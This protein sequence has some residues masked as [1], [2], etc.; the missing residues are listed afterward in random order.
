MWRPCGV[1]DE[2][3]QK[4]M[5]IV[6]TPLRW[7]ALLASLL[8]LGI[9]PQV[10]SYHLIS[11]VNNVAITV[12]LV[13]GLQVVS[14]YCGQ[15]S[16]GQA[17]FMAVGAY[18][19]AI[20]TEKM[21]I[22]FW[23]AMPVAGIF[24][25]IFGLVG[26]APSLRI[27]GFY[28]AIA[29]IAVH[30]VTMWL[31]LHLEITEGSR[32]LTVK[33]PQLWSVSLDTDE[34]MYYVIIPVMLLMTYGAKN[35]T[36]TRVGRAFVAIRDNDLAAQVMGI[37]LF[38][39]KL[40]AFFISCFYAG[41]AGALWAHLNLVVHFEQFTLLHALW[42]VGMLI[43]GGMGSIPGVFFGV[44]LIKLLDELVMVVS[45]ILA[46]WFPWLGTAPAA[47][48]GVTAFGAVLAFFLIKEPRGLAHRWE[49]IKAS[50]RLYPFA[51]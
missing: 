12:I 29:T 9:L 38:Y 4:D 7:A 30:F 18:C 36:R 41:I 27:K 8:A 13:L 50:I 31:I 3:Y 33:P 26:G 11:F 42:Y 10:A 14:G 44:I 32:G 19:S 22:S 40:L 16:F 15:I 20:L 1:F 5:A 34:K 43:V 2:T 49:I 39:Y 51:H 35:I 46:A 48:L 37:N 28:L 24:T 47:G 21:G 45:P 23:L 17:A 6:R 25:G